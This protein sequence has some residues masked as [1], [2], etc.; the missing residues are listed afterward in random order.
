MATDTSTTG[1][2]PGGRPTL[3]PLS[4]QALVVRGIIV[5]LIVIASLFVWRFARSAIVQPFDSLV[6]EQACRS[7]GEELGR[8][9]IDVERSNRFGLRNRTYG[10]CQFGP[11]EG[12][13]GTIQRSLDQI[14]FGSL[15]RLAKAA[16]IITQL[17]V[18]SVFLR[19]VVDPAMDV[20]R[21]IVRF[22]SR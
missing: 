19:F 15:Y 4:P 18:V 1:A 6:T 14:E 2:A 16:G 7:H 21:L 22:L 20:Y 11:T 12:G 10:Y 8:S 17:A 13:Q 3:G 9:L 5:A